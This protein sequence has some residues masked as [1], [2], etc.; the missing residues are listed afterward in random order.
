MVVEKSFSQ[1][2]DSL[3]SDTL[4]V[5]IFSSFRFRLHRLQL[6]NTRKMPNVNSVAEPLFFSGS[7][8][9]SRV[10]L[11][12]LITTVYILLISRYKEDGLSLH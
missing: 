6:R 2:P 4:T 7:G 10:Q 12:K 3:Q 8:S 11:L 5:V 9:S 1:N